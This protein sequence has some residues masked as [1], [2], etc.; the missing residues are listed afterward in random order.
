MNG[1]VTLF[2]IGYENRTLTALVRDLRERGVERLVD[3]RQNPSS[4]QRGFSL[5]SLFEGLR[6]AGISYDHVPQLGNPPA[7]RAAFY[8]GK[9]DD[10]RRRYRK[11]LLNGSRPAVD[12]LI[13]V[14]KMEPTAI[15]CREAEADAC[16]RG[17]IAEVVEAEAG[18]AIEHL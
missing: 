11:H 3:V 7:I 16:H 2:T 1:N 9:L 15:L 12:Y 6:K 17:V 14:V 4:R 8:A 13:Q 18:I 5:M 10:G